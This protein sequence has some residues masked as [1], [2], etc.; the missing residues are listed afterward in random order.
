MT[1]WY[2][3]LEK[4]LA[5][6]LGN[7]PGPLEGVPRWYGSWQK[8]LAGGTGFRYGVPIGCLAGRSGRYRFVVGVLRALSRRRCRWRLGS[9]GANGGAPPLRATDR[10]TDRPAPAR[11]THRAASVRYGRA[12][13]G[14]AGSVRSRRTM[15][16]PTGGHP[17]V[18][19]I[20]PDAIGPRLTV[21]AA[22]A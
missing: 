13:G 14:R 17:R 11:W 19:A 22:C 16:A 20:G 18:D 12:A 10:P 4:L 3:D 21:V 8:L 5:N 15:A 1:R 7:G 2:G 6:F 9:L